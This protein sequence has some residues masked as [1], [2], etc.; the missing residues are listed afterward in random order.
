M[1][2]GRDLFLSVADQRQDR[3]L[4]VNGVLSPLPL[5]PTAV[6][7][8]LLLA[9]PTRT[10]FSAGTDRW[11]PRPPD[12]GVMATQWRRPR[13][14]SRPTWGTR[15]SGSGSTATAICCPVP[16]T[17][18]PSCSSPPRP[19]AGRRGVPS[20]SPG[21][22]RGQADSRLRLECRNAAHYCS[23]E[24]QRMCVVERGGYRNL[25]PGPSIPPGRLRSGSVV[26][27]PSLVAL[28]GSGRLQ[29]RRRRWLSQAK[30]AAQRPRTRSSTAELGVSVE[31]PA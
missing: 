25:R 3:A 27:P 29:G 10:H 18:Q 2:L 28:A 19:P 14:R 23:V 11:N 15:V 17:R 21:G 7:L 9:R 8:S 22:G 1:A 16:R 6:V 12:I 30:R 5:A 4:G 20:S 24:S 13:T 26:A 31:T